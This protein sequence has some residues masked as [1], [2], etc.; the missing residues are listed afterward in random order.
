MNPESRHDHEA[1]PAGETL[2]VPGHLLDANSAV[3]AFPIL[4]GPLGSAGGRRRTRWVVAAA[5]L[6][7]PATLR[8][9]RVE[10][11]KLVPAA[12]KA[13]WPFIVP[14]ALLD[15]IAM[16]SSDAFQGR[17]PATE[18][19]TRT[20]RFLEQRFGELGLEPGNP[21]GTYRQKVPMVGITADPGAQ[22][23]FRRAS[24]APASM[25]LRY[26]GDFVAWTKREEP[27]VGIHAELVFAGY[28]IVAPEYDRDDYQGADLRGKVLVMLINDPPVRDPRNPSRLDPRAFQGK[29]M[30]YYGR[31]TYKFEMAAR[32]GAAGALIIHQAGPAG[33]PWSVVA[34]SWSGEGAAPSK[35]G[36]ARP[37]A[38]RGR[39]RPGRDRSGRAF[40]F[41]NSAY[42]WG[43]R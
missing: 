12:E 40:R 24:G 34:G 3:A 33:Y 29:A 6:L 2:R 27:Q 26:G 14:S 8:A 41:R 20:L 43:R 22:L 37:A 4:T 9:Q 28:G 23:V 25:A 42:P 18:G 1:R 15:D 31:W 32:R 11:A 38:V 17:A 30:T 10:P 13:A 5:I 36:K 35:A 16:L 7:A 21:D 19:E 39:R